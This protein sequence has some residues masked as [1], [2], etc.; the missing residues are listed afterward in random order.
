[1]LTF[2]VL[3]ALMMS[4]DGAYTSA[5]DQLRL[6]PGQAAECLRQWAA[7]CRQWT[8]RAVGLDGYGTLAVMLCRPRSLPFI[9]VLP[10]QHHG[11]AFLSIMRI[12]LA[13]QLTSLPYSLSSSSPPQTTSGGA[14]FWGAATCQR[15]LAELYLR[16]AEL[17][18]L[19]PLDEPLEPEEHVQ[20]GTGPGLQGTA[21]SS[22]RDY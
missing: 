11:T 8:V 20:V 10:R 7:L 18:R 5:N 4:W 17:A 6:L 1:M 9:A 15:A 19:P 21:V 14:A 2:G 3:I 22:E 12:A 16:L 13:T